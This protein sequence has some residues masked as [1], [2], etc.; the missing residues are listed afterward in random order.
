M[1]LGLNRRATRLADALA[2]DAALLGISATEL[3]GGRASSTAVSPRP[4]GSRRVGGSRRSA[5]PGWPRSPSRRWTWVASGSRGGGDHGPP[6]GGVSRQPVRGLGYRSPGYFAMGSG[7]ARSAARVERALYERIGH[8]E[9]P[10]TA[11][12][13]LE[14]RTLPDE[15]SC[16]SSPRSASVRPDGLRILIAPT[17]SIAGCVQV[18]ARSVETGLHKMLELGFDVNTVRSGTGVCP[19][20]PVAKNDLRAIGWT[21]DCILY[22]TRAYF[23]VHADDAAVQAMVERLPATASSD[24][25]TPFYEIFKRA[26]ND[27]YKIDRMLFSPAEV[28]VNNLASGRL[29]T[30]GR[31]NA[32]VL[33]ASFG[34][35]LRMK[36]A[37]LGSRSGWH[38]VRLSRALSE[39]G[40]EPVVGPVTGLAASIGD[41]VRLTA[42]GLPLDDCGAVV[43]RAIPSGSLEQVI[44]RIDAL[45]RLARLGVPVIN[46][47]RCV[48]ALRGQVL[49]VDAPRGCGRAHAADPC[50]RARRRRPGGVRGARRRRGRQAALRLRGARH[51]AGVRSRSR[52]PNL[53]GARGGA[54]RLLPSGIRPARGRDI[55][56]FVVGGRVVAAMIRRASGWKTNVSQGA[57]TEPARP[58][59]R[60]ESLSLGAATLLEA[61]YAGIDLLHAEDGRVLVIEVNGIPGWRGLQQTTDVDIAGVIAEHAIAAVERGVPAAT[62]P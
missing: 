29:Y 52:L 3:A 50:V 38:E 34:L 7:P 57:R 30:A 49:H 37:I 25:G 17:A 43:V 19:L 32:D 23:A 41:G 26:G 4:V 61:D 40:V 11:V 62:A 33:R 6:G 27:F 21:N 48:R 31:L 59:R 16:A 35:A 53:P 36:V 60:A 14:G 9:A 45:H 18:A 22:G 56:A 20:A 58:V 5:W 42:A 1:D 51:R 10:D 55:R 28:V 24:Y 13:V 15:G 8:A 47:P 39:R 44:F 54:L 12:L 2:E 46:S